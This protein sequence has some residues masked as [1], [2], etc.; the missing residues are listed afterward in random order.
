MD[1]CDPP[2]PAT[3]QAGDD[4]GFVPLDRRQVLF[5]DWTPGNLQAH[6]ENVEVY[7]NCEE[8]ELFLNG[9]SLGAKPLPRDASPRNWKVPY[10]AGTLK[11]VG[12]INGKNVAT[13]ELRTAGKPAKIL[14]SADQKQLAPGWDDVAFV[15]ATVVDKQGVII[16]NASDLITF[17]ITGP[18][19]VAAVDSA[20]NSSHEPF[21]ASER[22]AYAGRCVAVLKATAP[23]GKI[24]LTASAPG[25]GS[26]SIKLSVR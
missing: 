5:A 4:P 26:S 3:Q 15:T 17:K 8:V 9:K 12:K 21:Q 22:H 24:T 2:S 10:E 16:P 19:V 11:A 25:L 7:S 6:E 1:E 14:L 18:G 20:D 13:S 23:S